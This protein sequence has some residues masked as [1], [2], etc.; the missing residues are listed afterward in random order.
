[1]NTIKAGRL[2]MS[3]F[4][5]FAVAAP[6]LCWQVDVNAKQSRISAG[7]QA[8]AR[9]VTLESSAPWERFSGLEQRKRASGAGPL[10]VLGLTLP[11]LWKHDFL[12]LV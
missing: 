4:I 5:F 9:V 2:C 1:M 11:L 7:G 8:G 3:D 10:P 12:L 6:G